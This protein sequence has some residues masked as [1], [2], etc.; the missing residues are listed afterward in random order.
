[1]LFRSMA[2]VTK[3]PYPSPYYAYF[4]F[5]FTDP[6]DRSRPHPLFADR[7][8]RRAIA[9]AVDRQTIA[10]ALLGDFGS[11]PHS[12]APPL[13]R[14]NSI[15]PDQIPF[16]PDAASRLLEGAG[17]TDRDG[18]GVRERR[19]MRLSFDVMTPSTSRSR[20]NAAVLMQEYVAAVEIGRASCRERV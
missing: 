18:D 9:M 19:G 10:T 7:N 20:S 16:D 1:M 8:V 13:V 14:T 2:H 6:D 5:N 11:L 12:L 15:Q 17:W 3:Y 4:A